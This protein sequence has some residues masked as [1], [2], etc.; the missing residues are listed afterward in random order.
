MLEKEKSNLKCDIGKLTNRKLLGWILQIPRIVWPDVKYLGKN[1]T[2]TTINNTPLK[3]DIIS[4]T[5]YENKDK[6]IF[7]FIHG[8]AWVLII[9]YCS[10]WDLENFHHYHYY[11]N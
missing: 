4:S 3:L 10:V 5:K 9:I 11:M 1:I 7:F 6:P 8:G 2:Y